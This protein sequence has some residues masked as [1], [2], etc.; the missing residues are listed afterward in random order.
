[1]KI[2]FSHTKNISL[3]KKTFI[4]FYIFFS[5]FFPLSVS[6]ATINKQINYQGKLTTSAGVAVT[7][8]TY[9]MEFILYDDPTLSG[10]HILWTETRTGVDKVQV[11]NGLFSVMLGEVTSLAGVDFNQTL[12]LGVN[13]GGT[14]TPGWDGEMTPRK[15]LGTVPSAVV[16]EGALNIIGGAAGTIPYQSAANT[17]AFSAVGIAGQA[18]ISGNTGSPTWFAPTLGSILFAGTSGALS[19]DNA[20]FF[21]DDTNKRLGIGTVTP[22]DKLEIASGNIMLS[23]GAND[24]PYIH[25]NGTFAPRLIFDN[26]A[27]DISITRNDVPTRNYVTLGLLGGVKA[28]VFTQSL[29][30]FGW[31]SS[32]TDS[33]S[34]SAVDTG[35]SRGAANK[36]YIGNG[37]SGDSSGTLV[38]TNVGIGIAAPTS[39]LHVVGGNN[40]VKINPSGNGTAISLINNSSSIA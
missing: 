27:G 22:A 29:G 36:V 12:Y 26:N 34:Q 32:G 15:K 30:M 3:L 4:Y 20:N 7:N 37:T 40:T 14:G 24:R 21:W 13:I 39:T 33:S 19:Q 8:G 17:T 2:L 23:G 10:V 9:N 11:T 16:A 1:M 5:V 6:E 18:L 25:T 31:T 35:L 28:G 38:A